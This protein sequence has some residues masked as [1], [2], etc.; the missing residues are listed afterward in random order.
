MV[1]VVRFLSS[2]MIPLI[3]VVVTMVFLLYQR[4]KAKRDCVLMK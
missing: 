3:F 2:V 1:V 4:A